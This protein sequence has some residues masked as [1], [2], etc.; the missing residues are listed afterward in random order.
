MK[1]NE[2]CLIFPYFGEW[3]GWFTYYL[4]SCEPNANIDFLFFSEILPPEHYPANV[5]FIFLTKERFIHL[6]RGKLDVQ[7]TLKNSYKL[8]EFKPAYGKIFEDYIEPYTFWGY[9][10]IDLL[11][12]DLNKFLSCEILDKYEIISPHINFIPGHFCILRNIPEIVNLF[13]RAANYKKV[14]SSER[15]HY[16]DEVFYKKGIDLSNKNAMFKNVKKRVR[17]QIFLNR[18]KKSLLFKFFKSTL[19]NRIIN[20]KENYN[21][22]LSDFNQIVKAYNLFKKTVFLQNNVYRDD[23][24]RL[25]AKDKHWD[26]KWEN[27]KL[28][29]NEQEIM[30]YH[31]QLTKYRN[32]FSIVEVSENALKILL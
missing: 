6:V 4:R 22:P 21:L 14:F 10:D 8:C 3:P 19:R 18:F 17:K 15:Y 5:K 23:V 7:I 20:K 1:N 9:G 13:S 31:F 2:V 32:E 16:F 29:L 25:S 27:G 26:I 30:Y 11:Y 12:G 24:M 28:F